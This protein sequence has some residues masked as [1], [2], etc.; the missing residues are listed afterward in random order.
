LVA[1][2]AAD[3]L[4]SGKPNCRA[5]KELQLRSWCL[6][7]MTSFVSDE[8]WFDSAPHCLSHPNQTA[9]PCQRCGI[10]GC[11]SCLNDLQLCDSCNLK[12]AAAKQSQIVNGIAWKLLL[13][14]VFLIFSVVLSPKRASLISSYV[15]LWFIPAICAFLVIRKRSPLAGFVGVFVSI[16]LLALQ[17]IAALESERWLQLADVAMLS[18]APIV[19]FWGSR[20]L[21]NQTSSPH[22]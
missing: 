17:A 10:F 5:N 1:L 15:L 13:A 3:L 20:N 2:F 8:S 4:K 22:T 18:I 9:L 6:I 14:P 7:T 12:N 21:L 19:A 11:P 16:A